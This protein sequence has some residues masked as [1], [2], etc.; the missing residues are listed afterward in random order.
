MTAI[1]GLLSQC[2]LNLV[3]HDIT[4]GSEN[5]AARFGSESIAQNRYPAAQNEI[6]SITLVP[7]IRI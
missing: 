5:V 1:C 4:Q 2:L 7:A 3:M 6:W